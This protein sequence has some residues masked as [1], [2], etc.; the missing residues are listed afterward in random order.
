MKDSVRLS[1][2][3]WRT[4]C[5][6]SGPCTGAPATDAARPLPDGTTASAGPP[7]ASR[8]SSVP[9]FQACSNVWCR[10]GSCFSVRR[11]G[12]ATTVCA[13]IPAVPCIAGTGLRFPPFSGSRGVS[14]VLRYFSPVRC[15]VSCVSVRNCIWGINFCMCQ[16]RYSGFYK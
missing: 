15:G 2:T 5:P 12:S 4:V 9:A 14:S 6:S 13:H 11:R 7:I 16:G 1:A 10:G 8:P 3:L